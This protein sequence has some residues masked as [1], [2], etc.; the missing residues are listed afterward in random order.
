MFYETFFP[1][2]QIRQAIRMQI[3]KYVGSIA[4]STEIT[5]GDQGSLE[6]KLPETG[7]CI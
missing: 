6:V 1:G 3:F 7:L 5:L 4:Q 2:K